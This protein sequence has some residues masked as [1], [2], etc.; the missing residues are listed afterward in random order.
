MRP[1]GKPC[2]TASSPRKRTGPSSR[3]SSPASKPG[4]DLVIGRTATFQVTRFDQVATG[5]IQRVL[6]A[7]NVGPRPD[8]PP[9]GRLG[10]ELQNVGEITNRGWEL[11][12]SL[13]SGGFA[14]TGAYSQVDSRVRK[15]AEGYT[16]DLRAGNRML[17]VPAQT[18][19]VIGSYT[20]SRWNAAVT[21][22]RAFDWISYD[23][24]ALAQAF[25]TTNRPTQ[26]YVGWNLREFWKEY[27]GVTR[28]RASVA[29]SLTRTLGITVS[30]DNLLNHQTG[31]PDNVTVLPGRTISFG[32]RTWF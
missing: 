20:A 5:L 10:S 11:Q 3:K 27:P 18:L 7:R 13:H 26:D 14:L 15:V 24:V 17:E 19:S 32:L 16:G 21:A 22:Y 8:G 29:V 2:G 30:G 9:S 23:R 12:G 25:A 4:L 28:L 31:E 6:L 1:P